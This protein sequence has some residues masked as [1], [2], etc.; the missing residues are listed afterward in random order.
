MPRFYLLSGAWDGW[1]GG[2]H[3]L[4][5]RTS[6]PHISVCGP[7]VPSIS[8]CGLRR[9]PFDSPG[10]RAFAGGRAARGSRR[11][12]R[13][14]VRGRGGARAPLV[15]ASNRGITRPSVEYAPCSTRSATLTRLAG[16]ISASCT[17]STGT[18]LAMQQDI[19][20]AMIVASRWTTCCPAAQWSFSSGTVTRT[21]G[22]TSGGRSARNGQCGRNASHTAPPPAERA[23]AAAGPHVPSDTSQTHSLPV[24]HHPG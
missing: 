20:A 9:G 18:P 1:C 22:G 10:R 16:T 13:R 14:G 19:A 17:G 23:P 7:G 3:S 21:S 15:C 2:S 6:P 4:R 8:R 5:H 24:F 11:W 12:C